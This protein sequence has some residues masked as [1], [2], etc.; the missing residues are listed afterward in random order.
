MHIKILVYF[1]YLYSLLVSLKK[2]TFISKS[3]WY[4]KEFIKIFGSHHQQ[5]FFYGSICSFQFSSLLLKKTKPS[6]NFLLKSSVRYEK[7]RSKYTLWRQFFV[8]KLLF[9]HIPMNIGIP[10]WILRK[11]T[12]LAQSRIEVAIV[13]HWISILSYGRLRYKVCGDKEIC[14]SVYCQAT[15][16]WRIVHPLLTAWLSDNS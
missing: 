10:F 2:N 13:F 9:L 8:I 3:V 11:N 6:H 1:W 12:L 16:Q 5:C 14:F 15:I 4:K 7:C